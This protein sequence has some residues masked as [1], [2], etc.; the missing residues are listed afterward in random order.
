MR[1]ARRARPPGSTDPTRRTGYV[2]AGPGLGREHLGEYPA[3]TLKQ[4]R[5]A[6]ENTLNAPS[7]AAAAMT[8]TKAALAEA[9]RPKASVRDLCE[10][11]ARNRIHGSDRF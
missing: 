1:I 7:G 11:Y 9:V 2:R 4:D 10:G 3:V 5:D 6:A 8:E